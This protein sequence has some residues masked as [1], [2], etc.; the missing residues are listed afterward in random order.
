MAEGGGQTE[1]NPSGWTVDTL[2]AH[3]D[4]KIVA[5]Q[6]RVDEQVDR[7]DERHATEV[8]E[9]AARFRQVNEFR[10][11]L[12]DL[13]KTMATRRELEAS[14]ASIAARM[15]EM[16]KDVSTLRSRI[17]VGPAELQQLQQGASKQAGRQEGISAL[18]GTLLAVGGLVLAFLI[19][20]TRDHGSA[21]GAALTYLF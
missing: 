7:I 20:V 13:G 8:S 10:G 2:K 5:V 21:A 1:R 11:A 9:T 14:I 15:D 12:D 18:T 3:L 16:S 6:L 19:W 4:E 17:D